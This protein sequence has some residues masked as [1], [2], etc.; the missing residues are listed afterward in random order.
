MALTTVELVKE[1]LQSGNLYS[2]EQLQPSVDAAIELIA[3][4]VDATA[5]EAEPAGLRVA[6]LGLAVDIFQAQVAPGGQMV[7]ASFAPSPFRLGRSLLNKYQG[8]IAQYT[9]VGGLV[10]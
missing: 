1:A 4:Y 7:D 10:G 3:A 9:E 6:A 8:L 2:D 5:F